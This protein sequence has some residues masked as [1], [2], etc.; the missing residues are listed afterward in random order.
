[1]LLAM[2]FQVGSHV[3]ASVGAASV[4]WF[5]PVRST[6]H[7]AYVAIYVGVLYFESLEQVLVTLPFLM[8]L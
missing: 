2:T 3:L 5:V 7:V 8:Q 1:M 4:N 6:T